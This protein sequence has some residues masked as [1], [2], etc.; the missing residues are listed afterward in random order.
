VQVTTRTCMAYSGGN[1]QGVAVTASNLGNIAACAGCTST[2]TPCPAVPACVTYQ[3]TIGAFSAC[4]VTCGSG[5]QSRTVSCT[6]FTY[7]NAVGA[8]NVFGAASTSTVDLDVCAQNGQ[9]CQGATSQPC[10]MCPVGNTMVAAPVFNPVVTPIFNPVVTP[11]AP[12]FTP[13]VNPTPIVTPVVTPVVTPPVVPVTPATCAKDA[14]CFGG[15][16]VCEGCCTGDGKATDGTDCWDQQYTRERCCNAAVRRSR[17]REA[18]PVNT[19]SSNALLP[20]LAACSG[21]IVISALVASTWMVATA[22]AKKALTEAKFESSND[23]AC[24]TE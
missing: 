3:C 7:N 12:V 15:K 13:I 11:I 20:A 2:T 21:L 4:S 18:A 5:V 8:G 16:Y 24:Q 6:A 10:T 19:D 17:A 14:T 9:P 22:R 1:M 23:I